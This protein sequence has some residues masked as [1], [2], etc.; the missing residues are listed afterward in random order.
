[1]SNKSK[2]DKINQLIKEAKKNICDA[3]FLA[4]ELRNSECSETKSL[5]NSIFHSEILLKNIYIAL[6]TEV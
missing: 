6:C 1:M 2:I 4:E 3:S 5:L